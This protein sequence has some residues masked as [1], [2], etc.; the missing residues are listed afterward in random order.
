MILV[1]G[2]TGFCFF[3][4]ALNPSARKASTSTLAADKVFSSAFGWVHTNTPTMPPSI[5]LFEP[6][7]LYFHRAISCSSWCIWLAK[8]IDSGEFQY[9]VT[10]YSCPLNGPSSQPIA[11]I[12]R[13]DNFRSASFS[14][15]SSASWRA[16][17]ARLRA[18]SEEALAVPAFVCANAATLTAFVASVTALPARVFASPALLLASLTNL[19]SDR[20][21]FPES[22]SFLCPYSYAAISAVTANQKKISP[23]PA[24]VRDRS[25][26][27]FSS[28]WAIE[29][30][31]TSKAKPAIDAASKSLCVLLTASSESHQGRRDTVR[32]IIVTC[33][34]L[35]ALFARTFLYVQRWRD[36]KRKVR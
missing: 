5:W 35:I 3:S 15:T 18:T 9:A 13:G 1:F 33:S 10:V 6:S 34:L 14:F 2:L 32:F 25:G 24:M 28:T 23:I 11:V 21:W 20:I 19:S 16:E 27:L 12:W 26:R 7:G 30:N 17:E 36:G 31:A 22:S 4:S 29:S 8:S